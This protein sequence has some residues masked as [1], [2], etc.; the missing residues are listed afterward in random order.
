IVDIEG[1][2]PVVPCLDGGGDDTFSCHVLMGRLNIVHLK[3]CVVG[4]R[5]RRVGILDDVD[6]GAAG[7]LQ[8]VQVVAVDHL[9]NQPQTQDIL[10]P[11]QGGILVLD[12]VRD[13]VDI[14]ESNVVR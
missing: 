3:G 4:R 9:G 8:P 13:V 10:V 12:V 14:L 7:Q 6:H 1:L 5:G 11:P 2:L